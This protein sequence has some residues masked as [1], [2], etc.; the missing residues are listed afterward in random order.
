M[1]TVY[2]TETYVCWMTW[3]ITGSKPFFQWE[4]FRRWSWFQQTERWCLNQSTTYSLN[5]AALHRSIEWKRYTSNFVWGWLQTNLCH[6]QR[7][8]A[9]EFSSISQED[10]ITPAHAAKTVQDMLDANRSFWLKGFWPPQL[11]DLNSFDLARGRTLRKI[12][13]THATA[14]QISSRI[15]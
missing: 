2:I 15:L 11:P 1:Y 5:H 8:F 10:K 6:L 14:T 13:A 12:L 3:R 9:E 4:K 7:S